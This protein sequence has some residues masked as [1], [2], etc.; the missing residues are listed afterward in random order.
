MKHHE[1]DSNLRTI[2]L[3]SQKLNFLIYIPGK[4]EKFPLLKIHST[5][6]APQIWIIQILVK[7]RKIEVF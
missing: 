3:K 1:I 4:P 2:F 6:S 5:K 7:S